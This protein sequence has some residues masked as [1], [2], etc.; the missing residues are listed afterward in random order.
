MSD[1]IQW[2]DV[3]TL[4]IEGKGFDDVE[5]FYDRLPARAQGSVPDPVWNLS[6]DSAGICA[7]F[8]SDATALHARWTLRK[9]RLAMEHMPAT[10]VSGLDLYVRVDGAWRWLAVG[11]PT[12][13]TNSVQ[14]CADMPPGTREYLLYLPLYNGVHEVAVGVPEGAS[15]APATPSPHRP[16]VFYGTS[17]TQG[18]CSSRTGTCHTAFL[19]RWL[20]WPVVNLGFSGNG[21]MEESVVERI[22]EIDAAVYVIDCLPNMNGE[23]VA[24]RAPKAVQLLRAA[25]PD[26]PI[27]LVEDRTYADAFLRMG[28]AESNR[29]N[30][31]ALR[32]A[33]ESL[34]GEGVTNLHY[35]PGDQLLGADGED[36]VDGS[37]PTDLGFMRQAEAFYPLLKSIVNA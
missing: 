35:L 2:S 24:E 14:L 19:G 21:R 13:P 1:S 8:T 7:R 18:G 6:R 9:E 20:D 28:R 36:T 32:R 17:I 26:T 15:V 31:A 27:I 3:A 30:R 16:I 23:L 22:A 25:R 29:A 12:G 4:T 33:Y 11:Q 34:Q 10:G 5:A 37:H